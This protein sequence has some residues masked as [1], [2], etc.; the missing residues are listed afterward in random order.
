MSSEA[1]DDRYK[2][3]GLAMETDR[4]HP[5]ACL[6]LELRRSVDHESCP[7]CRCTLASVNSTRKSRRLH[8]LHDEI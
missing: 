7:N 1:K 4:A 8:A 5:A 6:A 2:L 3:G